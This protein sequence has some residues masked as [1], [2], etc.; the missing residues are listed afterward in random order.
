MLLLKG[1]EILLDHFDLVRDDTKGLATP[2][3]KGIQGVM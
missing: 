1:E 3:V 2:R